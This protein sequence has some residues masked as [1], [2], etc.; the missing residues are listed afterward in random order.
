MKL[1]LELF[2]QTFVHE[3]T[4]EEAK[5]ITVIIDGDLRH[6]L[7][8]IINIDP[9]YR[10]YAH[11]IAEALVRGNNQTKSGR[12]M[13]DELFIFEE[14]LHRESDGH[15]VAGVRLMIT[16]GFKNL[17]DQQLALGGCKGYS[18]ISGAML[19][20]GLMDILN[21]CKEKAIRHG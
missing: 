1:Q 4:K 20:T 21:E 18:D 6:I 16:G 9:S 8:A 3:K 5:G 2:E 10:G 11:I 14:D 12:Y 13:N 19:K 17:L 7:D 15:A